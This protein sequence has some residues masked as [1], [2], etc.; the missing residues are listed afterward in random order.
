MIAQGSVLSPPPSIRWRHVVRRNAPNALSP[1]DGKPKPPR[2]RMRA[3]L[4]VS[5]RQLVSVHGK[6]A[7]NARHRFW[8]RV[9]HATIQLARSTPSTSQG[10]S[11]PINA[12]R[13]MMSSLCI[14]ATTGFIRSVSGRWRA[15]VFRS[16][17]CPAI[18]V[19]ERRASGG[20]GIV[21][22]GINGTCDHSSICAFKGPRPPVY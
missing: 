21:I 22:A 13:A 5:A 9:A 2:S 6:S 18:S 11:D 1:H 20:R 10:F 14:G 15:P 4:F 12:A 7:L 17:S 19:G 3:R 16:L 8:T